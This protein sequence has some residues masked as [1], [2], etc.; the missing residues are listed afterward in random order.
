MNCKRLSICFGICVLLTVCACSSDE[1]SKPAEPPAEGP[2]THG[3]PVEPGT[4]APKEEEPDE[5]VVDEPVE[6]P[7]STGTEPVEIDDIDDLQDD[8]IVDETGTL[9]ETE[10]GTL[11][12]NKKSIFIASTAALGAF[13]VK[14]SDAPQKP[15]SIAVVSEDDALG[16]VT[17]KQI[18][19]TDK[20]WNE[21]QE[22]T[23]TRALSEPPAEDKVFYVKLG[24]SQSEDEQFTNLDA[25]VRVILRKKVD[26][27]IPLESIKI[28][29]S[30]EDLLF[31]DT[32]TL[33]AELT[34]VSTTQTDLEWSVTHD[35][36]TENEK[37][38][39]FDKKVIDENKYVYLNT[40]LV[41]MKP[42]GT[43]C[44][45]TGNSRLAKTIT[46]TVKAKDTNISQTIKINLKPYAPLKFKFSEIKK[47]IKDFKTSG[48]STKVKKNED[49]T[50]DNSDVT[51]QSFGDLP[52][53]WDSEKFTNV[54]KDTLKVLNHDLYIKYVLPN[55]Y[56]KTNSDG[57]KTYYG[58]RA[59]VVA[60]ARFLVL[61]FPYD[62][63]Y[64][65]DV[66]NPES[67]NN[68][69]D[70]KCKPSEENCLNNRGMSHYVWSSLKKDND[71]RVFGLNLS[72][73][74]YG[75][76]KSEKILKKDNTPYEA[77]PWGVE[78]E[79]ASG[80]F[81][82]SDDSVYDINKNDNNKP[83]PPNGLA[84]SGFV[85]WAFRNGRFNL[86]DW[87]TG[88]FAMR[89]VKCD[90]PDNIAKCEDKDKQLYCNKKG[91]GCKN[92]VRNYKYKEDK[93]GKTVYYTN[94]TNINN[95]RDYLYSKLEGLSKED[96]IAIN[97]SDDFK[98]M[99]KEDNNIKQEIKAGDLL[100]RRCYS[101]KSGH[102]AMILG[103]KKD[104]KNNPTYIYVGEAVD[105]SGN[106]LRSYSWDAF[107]NINHVNKKGELSP[108]PWLVSSSC[109]NGCWESYIIKMYKVYNYMK[110]KDHLDVDLD[111]YKY[112]DYWIN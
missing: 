2:G 1:N 96:F 3:T 75:D 102:V 83:M 94:N 53:D 8:D 42:N 86:G 106:L 33:T 50:P 5:P 84:C 43:E 24:P 7:P 92:A 38:A 65:K 58:T 111:T 23:V 101:S 69:D 107:T 89:G 47:Y 22:V 30:S 78:I 45:L 52:K 76:Y 59:S 91:D 14:L 108:S 55:M 44:E 40:N 66:F 13:T 90:C 79:A 82:C 77:I 62:I 110:D 64:Y 32:I 105:A 88:V 27:P 73:Q 19:F 39:I 95:S 60:A 99:F 71:V 46:V 11:V 85:S 26:K 103:I 6:L 34:P 67:C 9:G 48:C 29:A 56:V 80:S 17:P 15:V 51:Y 20:N 100:W 25:S 28:T 41:D 4:E 31:K 37:S 12:M 21:A 109:P 93:E 112:T 68:N 81:K 104:K 63:P 98:K 72:K 36:L 49:Y 10:P 61:Q 74:M 35:A 87:Y 97:D 18:E 70:C 16:I 54:F 57:K